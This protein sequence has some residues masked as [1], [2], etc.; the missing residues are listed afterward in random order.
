MRHDD[1]AR[2]KDDSARSK[3]PFT[4]ERNRSAT[5]RIALNRG[6]AAVKDLGDDAY[7]PAPEMPGLDG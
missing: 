2:S 7:Y 3:G 1:E 5:G 4:P 6:R